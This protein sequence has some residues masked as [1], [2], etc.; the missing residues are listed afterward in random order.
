MT[1][2]ARRRPA[3][4]HSDS[5]ALDPHAP[6]GSTCA[7]VGRQRAPGTG[8][9]PQ[10]A[11]SGGRAARRG[12]TRGADMVATTATATAG[13]PANGGGGGGEAED[14]GGRAG[15]DTR[16][17]DRGG[18]GE[19]AP[20]MARGGGGQE[21]ER[22]DDEQQVGSQMPRSRKPAHP[23][24][25]HAVLPPPLSTDPGGQRSAW[26]QPTMGPH[27]AGEGL[28]R[29]RAR[30]DRRGTRH[31][32]HHNGR[33]GG[34]A[35]SGPRVGPISWCICVRVGMCTD[36]FGQPGQSMGQPVFRSAQMSREWT[37]WK[38]QSE[39]LRRM[40]I[41]HP[42][43]SSRPSSAE[44]R[45]WVPPPAHRSGPSRQWRRVAF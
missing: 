12:V 19:Q 28:C 26:K 11:A 16:A 15:G 32:H 18:G 31:H 38:R 24:F 44:L 43:P 30:H 23:S 8:A 34:D 40:R 10:K 36:R 13:A 14:G 21:V 33:L 41:R 37:N 2:P 6:C 22:E 17:I 27:C 39:I 20:A 4:E 3:A 9:P 45:R 42:L 25:R 35:A 7:C 1:W 29:L 5:A